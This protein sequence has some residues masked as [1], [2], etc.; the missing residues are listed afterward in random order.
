MPRSISLTSLG[1]VPDIQKMD[2]WYAGR[3]WQ[4]K[5]DSNLLD[6]FQDNS[7][8]ASRPCIDFSDVS[9]YFLSH[10]EVVYM[11][12]VTTGHYVLAAIKLFLPQVRAIPR[13]FYPYATL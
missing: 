9:R 8:Q 10:E 6:P 2:T 13:W 4:M 5:T 1:G 3:S 11:G 12:T 7:F